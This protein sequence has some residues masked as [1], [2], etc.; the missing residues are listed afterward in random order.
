[1]GFEQI[2]FTS[3]TWIWALPII[4]MAFDV[5]TGYLNAW[6]KHEIQS[7]KMRSGIVKKAGEISAIL[8]LEII[9]FA[10]EIPFDLVKFFSIL[11]TFTEIN[12]IIENLDKM[13]VP[14]PIWIK[15]RVN[16]S[17]ETM[18]NTDVI[19]KEKEDDQS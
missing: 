18:T 15:S 2:T 16:N 19:E 3:Q 9:T 1:M 10:M 14:I 13:G 7:S 8:V 17:I 5:V 4:M 6:A 11:I 12:S